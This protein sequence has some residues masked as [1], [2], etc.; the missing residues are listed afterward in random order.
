MKKF[1]SVLLCCVLAV[2]CFALVGCGDDS[3]DTA[4]TK[5]IKVWVHKSEAEDEGK[6]YRAIEELF[7]EEDFKTDDDRDIVM[8]IEFKNSADTLNTSISA[9]VLTG[10]LPD[11]VAVDAPNIT[12]YADDGI[13]TPIGEHLSQESLDSYVDSVIEQGTVGDKL[14]A[15]S[16]MDAP[17]GLYYNKELLESIGYGTESKPFGS[18]ENP[19]SWTDVLNAMKELKAAGGGKAYRFKSNLGFGGD[20]GCMYLYSSLIYSAGGSFF[21]ENEKVVGSLN[22]EN[23]VNGLKAFEKLYLENDKMPEGEEYIYNGTN[24][25]AFAT[26][27]VAFQI[28][29]P[30]DV[31][32][33]NKVYPDFKNKYDIMPFPVYSDENNQNKGTVATPCGS[34]GFGVTPNTKDA[35]SAAIVVEYLTN[36]QSSRLLYESIGTFPTHKSL[37]DEID[38][39]KTGA[40]KSLADLLIETATPRPKMVKYPELSAAYS[41]IIEYIG[42]QTSLKDYNL[43]TFVTSKATSVDR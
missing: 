13:L 10:G 9:E 30:W 41:D 2:G 28:Y 1:L 24:V 27:E 7:N 40:L 16:G 38:A 31:T 42:S 19:W 8:K 23:S 37:Y 25:N 20:E 34:W 33:I 4:T 32:T 21:G 29:G 26:G 5:V 11:V 14:Y 6:V 12:A 3:G 17:A 22:S 39:F 18:I 36:A 43:S 35:K 15:L